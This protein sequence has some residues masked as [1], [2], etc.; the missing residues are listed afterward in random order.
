MAPLS[1]ALR[2][3]LFRVQDDQINTSV[4]PEIAAT[5]A[6]AHLASQIPEA[7][8]STPIAV[9]DFLQS[10]LS[11]E[12]QTFMAEFGYLSPVATDISVPTWKEQPE[13]VAQSIQLL[14]EKDAKQYSKCSKSSPKRLQLKGRS[15]P[16]LQS[17]TGISQRIFFSVGT[18][19]DPTR[20]LTTTWRYL[21]FK[22]VRD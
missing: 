19:M 8:E 20:L 16:N 7:V 22:L 10:E 9:L 17:L 1:F 4:L 5:K 11:H 3:K 15:R 12:W 2:Q 13:I 21:L 14:R 18:T 6:I